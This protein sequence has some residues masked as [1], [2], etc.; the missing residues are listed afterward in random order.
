MKILNWELISNPLNWA[1]LFLMVAI[2]FI[3][4]GYVVSSADL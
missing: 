3:G 2:A 4:A 1:I